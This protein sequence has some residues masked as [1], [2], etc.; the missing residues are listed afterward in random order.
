MLFTLFVAVLAAMIW[1]LRSAVIKDDGTGIPHDPTTLELAAMAAITVAVYA[2]MK[3]LRTIR[4]Q[5]AASEV[6]V[7]PS[8]PERYVDAVVERVREESLETAEHAA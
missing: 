1:A 5:M 4:Q 2:W 7:T 3:R 6:A 8:V